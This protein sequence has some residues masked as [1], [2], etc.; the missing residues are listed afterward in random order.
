M[1]L[2]IVK[3]T[4]VDK[5]IRELYNYIFY[6]SYNKKMLNYMKNIITLLEDNNISGWVLLKA[7]MILNQYS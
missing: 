6:Q 7:K 3:D 1:Y 5:E 4:P 2:Y